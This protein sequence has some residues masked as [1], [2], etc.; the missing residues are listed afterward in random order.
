MALFGKKQGGLAD[1][2]RCDEQSYLIWKWHPE[3]VEPGSGRENAIRWGS[4]IRVKEGSVAIFFYNQIN[5]TLQD[6]LEGPYDGVIKTENL[7]VL[8]TLIGKFFDGKSPFQAEVYFI[9]LAEIIQSRFAIPYFDLYDYRFLDYGIPTA[10]RGNLTF[11]IS[12]YKN[13]IKLHRL[14]EFSVEDFKRQ[15]SYAVSRYVK[16][17]VAD[18]SKK[19]SIPAIQLESKLID[20]NAEAEALVQYRLARDF[21]INVSGMDIEAIDIDK[22]SPGYRQLMA[23]TKDISART[24]AAQTDV[25]IKNL[26]DMQRINIENTS[27]S[28]RI[29]RDESQYAQHKQTQQQN[30][31]AYKIEQQ[32]AVGIAGA[33]ALG[34]MGANGS[35]D[36][37]TGAPGSMNIAAAM[38]GIALGGAV[39][40]NLVNAVTGA[41]GNAGQ[42]NSVTPMNTTPPPVPASLYNVVINGESSGPFE[43]S[44]LTQ[45]YVGGQIDGSTLVW[46]PGMSNWTPLKQVQ[47]LQSII[48][49]IPPIPKG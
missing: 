7:P 5:G 19:Y 33:N 6:Y 2:I 31:G 42:A 22:S 24:I 26:Y 39:G 4:S 21:G 18:A 35:L 1:I 9:N 10:V 37:N 29:Q 43:L 15:I 36:V 45:M 16:G 13:F 23:V 27:E 49:S 46:K 40:Q 3:G 48:V 28:L 32:T 44:T 8:S 34:Q 20:I 12:N 38:T 47:E 41:F 17:V 25:N 11:R 14:E 30:I